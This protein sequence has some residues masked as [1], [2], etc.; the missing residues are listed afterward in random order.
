MGV[1]KP[2]W[3]GKKMN[4]NSYSCNKGCP[5]EAA[6]EVIGGKWKGI[7][8]YHL[9]SDTVRFNEFRK[10]MPDI[11]QRMLT[12]QLRDLEA[13]QLI[14]RKVYAE[15]P[16]RVEYSMTD[17][18]MTLKPVILALRDWGAEHLKQ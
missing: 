15:V 10:I 8:L 18:G 4:H 2:L 12:K 16:P 1:S 5:V 17:Y 14:S 7:I 3:A 13:S 6:L 11:T 9:L